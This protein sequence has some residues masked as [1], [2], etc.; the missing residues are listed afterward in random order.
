[1]DTVIVEILDR[2]GKIKERHRIDKFPC[3][4]GRGY[5]NTII[6]D[7]PYI[8]PQHLVISNKNDSLVIKD[9]DSRNG[10][11]SLQPFSKQSEILIKDD[12]RIRVGHTD[13]RFRFT[14]HKIR[15]TIEE[16][17]KPSQISMLLTSGFILP[18]VWIVFIAAM[19]ANNYIED[20]S[21]I[22]L[23]RL[24]SDVYPIMIFLVLWALGWSIISKIVT[25]RFY[26]AFHAIWVCCLTLASIVIDNFA[27]YYEFSFAVTGSADFINLVM[28][29]VVTTILF[30]GH[31]HYS[32]SLSPARAKKMALVSAVVILGLV[33][34]GSLL[35]SP[36]FSNTPEYSGI[37]RPAF[38]I[39]AKKQTLDDFFKDTNMLKQQVDTA[40]AEDS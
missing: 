1:M 11:F 36:E 5:Q 21:N 25:H 10:L 4:I 6:L 24:L 8:S 27:N 30:Y 17:D 15:D 14:N 20:T 16:R 26:F 40:T 39:M 13:L 33:E 22:T 31:L 19:A 35:R 32:T 34:L 12:T 23:Q 38:F 28:D 3:T 9:T 7:D 37:I 18:V 29:I 2:F